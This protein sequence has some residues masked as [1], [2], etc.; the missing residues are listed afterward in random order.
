MLAAKGALDATLAQK[1]AAGVKVRNL[2]GHAYAQV[3]PVKIHAAAG[4]LVSLLEAFCAAMVAFAEAT[5][6]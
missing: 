4:E 5:A 6:R 1:L 3:D 2:I